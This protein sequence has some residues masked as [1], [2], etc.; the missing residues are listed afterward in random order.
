V[1]EY[2]APPSPLFPLAV[3]DG[4]E[5][6]DAYPFAPVPVFRSR[7][8]AD[9][10]VDTPVAYPGCIGVMFLAVASPRR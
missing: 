9:G 8:S 2:P 4:A 1:D 6:A 10:A 5:A 3:F 7:C